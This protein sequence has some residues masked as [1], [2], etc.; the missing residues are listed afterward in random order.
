MSPVIGY[1][2]QTTEPKEE[3]VTRTPVTVTLVPSGKRIGP[4]MGMS[5]YADEFVTRKKNMASGRRHSWGSVEHAGRT[6]PE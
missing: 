6:E 1:P 2:C 4:E 5:L 3:G